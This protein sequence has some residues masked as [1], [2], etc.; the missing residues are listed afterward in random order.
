M[1]FS[2]RYN[3]KPARSVAQKDT[4]DDSL[5]NGI[6]DAFHVCVWE[7]V[8]VPQYFSSSN[9]FALFQRYWHSYFHF[10]LDSLPTNSY[11]ALTKVN[12]YFFSCTWNEIYDFIEFTAKMAPAEMANGFVNFCNHVLERDLSAYRF[13]DNQIVEITSETEITSI[14]EALDITRGLGGVNMHLD[15]A[16]SLLSDRKQPDYRNSIKE[17]ISAVEAMAQL[18]TGDHKATLGAALKTLESKSIIHP[19]LQ[20][21]YAQIYGYTSD[22]DGIRH[23]MVDEPNINHCDAKFMLVSCTAFINYLIQKASDNNIKFS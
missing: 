19:A 8:D 10:T 16:I 11:D 14:E 15:T 9:L 13:V 1:S 4:M 21:S 6:W 2:E 18:I 23:A 7:K 5:R 3:L 20:K 17:S 22:A 12:N